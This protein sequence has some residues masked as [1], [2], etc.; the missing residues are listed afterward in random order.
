ML[1]RK[2]AEL[3]RIE[4]TTGAPVDPNWHDTFL[5]HFGHVI[6]RGKQAR[7]PTAV[8]LKRQRRMHPDIGELV[9]RVFY[10]DSDGLEHDPSTQRP[11]GVTFPGMDPSAAF[12]W[13]DTS[14]LGTAAGDQGLVNNVEVR[15]AGFLL[16]REFRPIRHDVSIPPLFVLSPYSAQVK[17][18]A[19]Y[20]RQT[21]REAI[22]TVDSVQG[23]GRDRDREPRPQT[24]RRPM[25]W[26]ASGSSKNLSASM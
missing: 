17:D 2:D 20:V 16:S 8:T 21:D 12:V 25:F 11:H 18:L 13:V 9:G 15:L 4:P 7:V 24:T 23:T 1:L 19:Q 5:R 26:P 14:S 22:R 10:Q 6:G 3:R